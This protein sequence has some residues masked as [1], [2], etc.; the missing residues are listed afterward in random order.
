[1][2]EAGLEMSRCSREDLERN[3]VGKDL[4]DLSKKG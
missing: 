1:M 2:R 3:G 4:R